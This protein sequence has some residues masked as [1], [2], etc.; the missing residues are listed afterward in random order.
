MSVNEYVI[1]FTKLSRYAPHEVDTDKK[2]QECFLNGWNDGLTYALE[3]QD[4]ENFQGIVNKDLVLEN[5]R[6][7]MEHKRKLVHQHQLGS[8]SRPHV[9]MPSA[10]PVFHP[11]QPLFQ[12]KPQV[13][14]QG[15][16]TLQHQV[17]PRPNPSQTPAVGNQ[18]VQR[19][20]ATQNPLQGERRCFAC[21]EKCHFANQCPSQRNRRPQT[22]VSTPVPTHGANSIP[23]A[24]R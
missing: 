16:S 18:N 13:A 1:K 23:V 21:G 11:A 20:Q 8:S 2:K 14:G 22:A 7:V 24:A 19:T 12:P 3:A 4:F 10:G 15:Y 9:A 17:M 5:R 6:A